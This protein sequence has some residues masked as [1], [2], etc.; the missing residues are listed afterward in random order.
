MSE[1]VYVTQEGLEELKREQEHL[2]HVLPPSTQ[3][4]FYNMNISPLSDYVH[5]FLYP[6]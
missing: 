4:Y 3:V 5:I 1:K 2:I 6:A